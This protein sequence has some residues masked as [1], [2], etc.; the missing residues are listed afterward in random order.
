MC[1]CVEID[2]IKYRP[3]VNDDPI[4][5]VVLDKGFV[6]VGRVSTEG[7]DILIQDARCLIKWGTTAHLG[8]LVDGPL[9]Y[10]KLGAYCTVQASQQSAHFI[11]V[12]QDAWT[13]DG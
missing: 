5:I 10:T 11:E 4:K 13:N 7:E 1:K 8:E 9:E 6:Y 2:G 12:N 3:V